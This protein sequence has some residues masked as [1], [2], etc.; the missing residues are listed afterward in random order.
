VTFSRR[1]RF[2]RGVRAIG[3]RKT[4]LTEMQCMMRQVGLVGGGPFRKRD[5]EK[6][7][8]ALLGEV[9]KC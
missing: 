2:S 9:S 1:K 8:P 4:A 7:V 6:L 3:R 5:R